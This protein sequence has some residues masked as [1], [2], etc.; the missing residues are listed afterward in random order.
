MSENDPH[1]VRSYF[2][3]TQERL[4]RLEDKIDNLAQTQI[5]IAQIDQRVIAMNNLAEQR[6]RLFEELKGHSEEQS[7]RIDELEKRGAAVRALERVGWVFA[8]AT[9]SILAYIAKEGLVSL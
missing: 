3:A 8:T 6:A 7:A 2:D 9:I 1:N 5:A 4:G